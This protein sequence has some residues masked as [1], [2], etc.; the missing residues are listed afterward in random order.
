M[1]RLHVVV[2]VIVNENLQVCIARRAKD[3]HLAGMWECPGGKVEAN[4]TALQALVR[5]LHEEI[6]IRV[7]TA[8]PLIAFDHDYPEASQYLHLD[9]WLVRDFTGEPHG[10]EGQAVQW[11]PIEALGK[12]YLLP[13]ADD[14][15][16]QK[17]K[18]HFLSESA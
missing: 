17:L 12:E 11:V 5:E 2:G 4:E 1:Q 3:V 18:S 6:G 7:H 15:M 9:F 10:K 16:L 8:Q 13:K 14:L